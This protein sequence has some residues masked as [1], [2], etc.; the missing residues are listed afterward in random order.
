[1]KR[2]KKKIFFIALL[3]LAAAIII[4]PKLTQYLSWQKAAQASGSMPYQIGLTKAVMVNC[5]TTGLPPFCAGGALCGTL[6][7]TRC[8]LYSEVSGTPAGGMGSN[9]LFSNVAIT[10]AGLTPGGQ[11]IAG[12]LSPTFMDQ[13]V[14]ASAGGCYG[15]AAK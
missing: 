8:A 10:E 7:V 4:K 6:D 1:M 14:L 5:F 11:L 15:C 9:A 12:G 2:K 3:F 13:G